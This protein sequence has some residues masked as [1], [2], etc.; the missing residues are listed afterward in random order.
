MAEEISEKL[1]T[2]KKSKK[3]GPKNTVNLFKPSQFRIKIH[4]ISD[5]FLKKVKY[6]KNFKIP[7]FSLLTKFKIDVLAIQ[8]LKR[9]KGEKQNLISLRTTKKTKYQVLIF[10]VT[11]TLPTVQLFY[12]FRDSTNLLAFPFCF[13]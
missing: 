7:T 6:L 12:P 8:I 3:N 2:N 1:L 10:I 11:C 13:G 5:F 9:S 4:E